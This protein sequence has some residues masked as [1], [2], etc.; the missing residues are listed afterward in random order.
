MDRDPDGRNESDDDERDAPTSVAK[1]PE[2]LLK[3][4]KERNATDAKVVLS[5]APATVVT[6]S[7]QDA[8]PQ[9]PPPLDELTDEDDSATNVL[10]AEKAPIR[11]A[12]PLPVSD[13]DQSETLYA[14]TAKSET[15]PTA[16]NETPVV[17]EESVDAAVVAPLTHDAKPSMWIWAAP[18]AIAIGI[19]A[20][21]TWVLVNHP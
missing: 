7:K 14:I 16:S 3:V 2:R 15:S 4:L 6:P 5:S 8:P 20:L 12:A 21:V 18:V 9:P 19:G 17:N 1:V 13:E 10:L 11:R